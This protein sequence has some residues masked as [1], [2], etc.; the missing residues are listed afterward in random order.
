MTR[1]FILPFIHI[2]LCLTS[3][4][5]FLAKPNENK[6]INKPA[7]IE[8]TNLNLFHVNT[9]KLFGEPALEAKYTECAYSEE[10][11]YVKLADLNLTDTEMG[12]LFKYIM[13]QGI[14]A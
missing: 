5:F 4:L 7:Y 1:I 13:L 3:T 12:E 6:D 11:V 2:A 10:S 9:G 8:P 14:F